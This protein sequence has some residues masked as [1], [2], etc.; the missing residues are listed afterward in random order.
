MLV[1]ELRVLILQWICDAGVYVYVTFPGHHWLCVFRVHDDGDVY[2]YGAYCLSRKTVLTKDP[3]HS[4]S[5]CL[6]SV[7]MNYLESLVHP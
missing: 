7:R 4:L 5:G 1:L 2:V 3:K 6:L